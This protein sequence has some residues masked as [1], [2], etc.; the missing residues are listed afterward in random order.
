MAALALVAL[1][2]SGFLQPSPA[3]AGRAAALAASPLDV[4]SVCHKFAAADGVQALVDALAPGE[5]GCLRSG[6]YGTYADTITV[7]ATRNGITLRSAPGESATVLGR[8]EVYGSDVTLAGLTLDGKSLVSHASSVTILGDRV[9]LI[10]NDITSSG[11]RICVN[12]GNWGDV[13]EDVVLDG[14]KVHAC[15]SS[16]V[17]GNQVHGVYV[18]YARRTRITN[19]FIFNNDARGLQLHYDGDYTFI[20]NNVIDQNGTG[21]QF[22]GDCFDANG[23][24]TEPPAGSTCAGA[25]LQVRR[26]ENNR[27]EYNI[28]TNSTLARVGEPYNVASYY[29]NVPPDGD[30]GNSVGYNCIYHQ[31][32]ASKNYPT[33]QV[34]FRIDPSN[35]EQQDPKF[36]N[37]TLPNPDYRLPEV[38]MAAYPSPCM[39]KGPMPSA[40]TDAVTGVTTGTA[41]LRGTIN[42]NW[43]TARYYFEYGTT[44]SYGS[45]TTDV[46]AG[47][48]PL[49]KQLAAPIAGL[50]AG[51][52][53]HYRLVAY[54][55]FGRRYGEDRTF[56]TTGVVVDDK[57]SGNRYDGWYGY[58]TSA[59]YGG[60][61]RY[62]STAGQT[63]SYRTS[64]A[65]T[66]I[67]MVT[68]RGSNQGIAEV[69][70]DGVSKGRIDLYSS[71]AQYQYV[72]AYSGLSST[73]HT[74]VV[75]VLGQRNAAS[76]GTQVR[77]D[78]FR[79]GTSTV[80][81][82]YPAVRFG[83]WGGTLDA[84][85]YG[86]SYRLSAT[87]GASTYFS[88]TGT[89]FT[90]IS[91]RGPAYGQ[92]QVYVDGVLKLTADQYSP[93]LQRQSLRTITGLSQS[94]HTVQIKV[95]GTR[96]PAST[97][98]TVVFD[99]WRLP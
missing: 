46:E 35:T 28:I 8:V 27:V 92:A 72:R 84:A 78:G 51:A 33:P 80:D 3:S 70:I 82:S 20:A 30:L 19:N 65:T 55:T 34:G 42:A 47:A 5:T 96:N 18:E 14:N 83:A 57:A 86:G 62:S 37:P 64:T 24:I 89:Q 22:S 91:A 7:P 38:G 50:T 6:T 94:S 66:S 52:T 79:V 68:Y 59:A 9:R 97:A 25:G 67:G 90:W 75:K 23:N 10:G 58:S 81:E 99:G 95:T 56:S 44:G 32:G 69:F 39:Q 26:T 29:D 43:T 61:L 16:A 12:I 40:R 54:N 2:L 76:T 4:S 49:P 77:V 36:R 74:V 48:E 21:I 11:T 53:Y 13:A 41:T 73:V 93:T 60:T 88:F 1:L 31:A 17:A 98:S 71:T 85:A 45:K 87:A 15:G 63:I